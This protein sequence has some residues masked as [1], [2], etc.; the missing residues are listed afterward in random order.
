MVLFVPNEYFSMCGVLTGAFEIHNK[1][2]VDICIVTRVRWTSSR[3]ILCVYVLCYMY[4]AD[5]HNM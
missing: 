2:H 4:D 3:I 5:E 1:L